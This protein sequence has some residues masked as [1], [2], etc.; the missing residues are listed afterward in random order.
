MSNL[1]A[2]KQLWMCHLVD[3]IEFLDIDSVEKLHKV[4]HHFYMLCRRHFFNRPIRLLDELYVSCDAYMWCQKK[5]RYDPIEVCKTFTVT[6]KRIAQISNDG[7]D[8]SNCNCSGVECSED[9]LEQYFSRGNIRFEHVV[10]QYD[11]DMHNNYEQ[12]LEPLKGKMH[13]TLEDSTLSVIIAGPRSQDFRTIVSFKL[14]ELLRYI[15]AKVCSSVDVSGPEN[16]LHSIYKSIGYPYQRM[17]TD[18]PLNTLSVKLPLKE[19]LQCCQ[20]GYCDKSGPQLV[21][22]VEEIVEW[23]HTSAKLDRPKCL[24]L[25]C[26]MDDWKRIV[27]KCI[28]EFENVNVPAS[29]TILVG[30]REY[31]Q[32]P[33]NTLILTQQLVNKTTGEKLVALPLGHKFR[34]H[35]TCDGI[36]RLPMNVETFI[37]KI[38][39]PFRHKLDPTLLR[40]A[41]IIQQKYISGNA[42]ID[43]EDTWGGSINH[44]QSFYRGKTE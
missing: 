19:L 21:C 42:N 37:Q 1:M 25:L 39:F 38:K 44:R 41:D 7:D 36:Q 16:Y 40:I 17:Q 5:Q 2:N 34:K 23:L 33:R 43:N 20:I 29:F 15:G 18:Y 9:N 30:I 6:Q 10:I 35:L 8:L 12:V 22:N 27:K 11:V 32:H 31:D 13:H 24:S 4:N 3:V 28:E 26:S 14:A